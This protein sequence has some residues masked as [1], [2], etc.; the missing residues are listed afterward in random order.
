MSDRRRWEEAKDLK[1]QTT[2]VFEDAS[3]TLHK[4]RS[5]A[6]EHEDEETHAKQYL[7]K[8]NGEELSILG[9]AWNKEHNE[10]SASFPEEKADVTKRDVLGKLSSI[11]DHLGLAFLVTL[12]AKVLYR[13]VCD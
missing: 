13:A 6:R 1:Q 3:F 8:P 2:E 4:R 5:S 9:L 11:Y 12:E 10:V 7:G